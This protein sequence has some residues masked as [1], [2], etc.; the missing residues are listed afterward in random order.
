MT[1]RCS[2]ELALRRLPSPL[3]DPFS[4][5]SSGRR[6]EPRESGGKIRSRCRS[7]TN[8]RW[9]PPTAVDALCRG[10]KRSRCGAPTAP[11]RGKKGRP[12]WVVV[13]A[14]ARGRRGARSATRQARSE[15][16]ATTRDSFSACLPISRLPK[17]RR[18]LQPPPPQLDK[19]AK[20]KFLRELLQAR[21]D[22]G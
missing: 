15:L 14:A 9:R 11:R 17:T 13:A 5:S 8:V 21:R 7:A 3:R 2:T 6:P 16:S 22:R 4:S 18:S 20:V 19:T 1:H 12:G 10:D